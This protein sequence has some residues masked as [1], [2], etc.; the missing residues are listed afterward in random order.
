MIMHVDKLQ[1]NTYT[2]LWPASI[3]CCLIKPRADVIHNERVFITGIVEGGVVGL[4]HSEEVGGM[5]SCRQLDNICDEC[6]DAQAKHMDPWKWNKSIRTELFP[7][8]Y[9]ANTT[10]HKQ[11]ED[12]ISLR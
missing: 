6:G 1:S 4:A 5:V 2:A 3:D 11:Q 10:F 12:F 7:Q 8:S 9:K